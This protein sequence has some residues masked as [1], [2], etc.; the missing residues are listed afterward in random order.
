MMLGTEPVVAPDADD[1]TD[2]DA[3]EAPALF[4]CAITRPGSVVRMKTVPRTTTIIRTKEDFE[5]CNGWL[6]IG[7][8]LDGW[9]G[10]AGPRKLAARVALA[11]RNGKAFCAAQ[12]LVG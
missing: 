2:D 10:Y 9:I 5:V 7:F 8:S 6:C 3:A 4:C 1:D 12:R 11:S